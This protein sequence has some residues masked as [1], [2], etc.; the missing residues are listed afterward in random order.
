MLP[1]DTPTS[2]MYTHARTRAHSIRVVRCVLVI[3]YVYKRA[4]CQSKRTFSSHTTDDTV[5]MEEEVD[6][7]SAATASGPY[8]KN[9]LG[10]YIHG[11]KAET[12][13]G[14]RDRV[15]VQL[16]R[17]T[18]RGRTRRSRRVKNDSLVFI[19]QS[20]NPSPQNFIIIIIDFFLLSFFADDSAA[21]SMH[22]YTNLKI[23]LW[24][25]SGDGSNDG[26]TTAADAAA[27]GGTA[28]IPFYSA[29]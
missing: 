24:S 26:P 14:V 10:M 12:L 4:K 27:E 22:N 8:A 5:T 29:V 2:R 9:S 11:Y 17:F 1:V 28:T 20:A 25:G 19:T 23:F 3:H 15:V 7:P 6:G 16:Q 13:S 18:E 21:D